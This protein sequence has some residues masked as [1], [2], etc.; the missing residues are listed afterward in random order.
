MVQ[1]FSPNPGS[2]GSQYLKVRCCERGMKALQLFEDETSYLL[3][4][5]KWIDTWIP[6]FKNSIFFM[7]RFFIGTP[8]FSLTF[9]PHTLQTSSLPDQSLKRDPLGKSTPLVHTALPLS[10]LYLARPDSSPLTTFSLPEFF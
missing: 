7:Y 4:E 2:L 9:H 3:P 8:V 6:R 1:C 10:F 5:Q